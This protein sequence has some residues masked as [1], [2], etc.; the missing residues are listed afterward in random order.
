MRVVGPVMPQSVEKRLA[1]A[2]IAAG[3]SLD[4]QISVRFPRGMERRQ[5]L[6]G[7]GTGV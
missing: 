4:A 2:H 7:R 6:E 3:V 5:T 1:G